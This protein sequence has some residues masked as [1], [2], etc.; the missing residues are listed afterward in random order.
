MPDTEKYP[1]YKD[2]SNKFI[3]VFMYGDCYFW[4]FLN[5]TKF[6]QKALVKLPNNS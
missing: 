5:K 3:Y 2:Q 1:H 4:P 6:S